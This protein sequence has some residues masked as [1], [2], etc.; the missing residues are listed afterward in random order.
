MSDTPSFAATDLAALLCS[1]V[2]H[3]I[4]SPVGAINNGLE[5]LD[6]NEGDA[7]MREF[8]MD[9]VRKSAQ[10]AS[11]KLQFARL[12]FGAAGSA[13]AQIDL[14]DAGNV[15]RGFV[16]AEKVAMTWT[17]PPLAIAKDHVKL[18]LNL[19]LTGLAAIPRGGTMSIEVTPEEDRLVEIVCRGKGARIPEGVPAYFAD[20]P[21]TP[22]DPHGVQPYYAGL[23]AKQ[24]GLSVTIEKPSEDVII[25][26]RR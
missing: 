21:P 3:D 23:I 10:Q 6:E 26:A 20:E 18:V 25:S 17:A 2:C 16:G 7:S 8:A 14:T 4:I 11:A 12:A 13:G 24:A 9:L 5:V 19:L 15:A 22:T 1:R